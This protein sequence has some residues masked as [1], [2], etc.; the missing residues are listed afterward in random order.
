M[1]GLPDEPLGQ[2]ECGGDVMARLAKTNEGRQAANAERPAGSS[3]FQICLKLR[4]EKCG[5]VCAVIDSHAGESII[6]AH[7]PDDE[8]VLLDKDRAPTARRCVKD[9]DD[10]IIA[11]RNNLVS[12]H[13]IT[14]F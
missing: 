4:P 7:V 2:G 5:L 10:H 8:A 14:S 9:A 3:G 1:C 12:N 11:I 13:V 6:T